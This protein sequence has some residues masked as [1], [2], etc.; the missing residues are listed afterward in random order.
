[1]SLLLTDLPLEEQLIVLRAMVECQSQRIIE[2]QMKIEQD[3]DGVIEYGTSVM[4]NQDRLFNRLTV[5][6]IYTDL[7]VADHDTEAK[8]WVCQVIQNHRTGSAK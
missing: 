7:G 4:T 5:G 1:M 6:F 8:D 2:L 3:G